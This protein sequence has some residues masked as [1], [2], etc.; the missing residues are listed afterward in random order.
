MDVW[1]VGCVKALTVATLRKKIV[2]RMAISK[3][4]AF[5]EHWTP[6]ELDRLKAMLAEKRSCHRAE[7]A[8][9]AIAMFPEKSEIRVR[10]MLK[11]LH[12]DEKKKKDDAVV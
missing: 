8:E 1:S 7:R 9:A 11:Y 12:H 2:E 5:A 10:T 6:D 4:I 3:A